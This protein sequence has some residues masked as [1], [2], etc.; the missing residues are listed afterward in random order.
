[1]TCGE[2]TGADI[3][4][5]IVNVN[6][7]VSATDA[8]VAAAQ[9]T[10]GRGTT[11]LGLTPR[12]GAD[13][14]DC[15]FESLLAAVAVMDAVVT[16]AP[17]DEEGVLAADA[18]ILG[19]FGEYGRDGLAE[20]LDVPVFDVAESGAH[21][22]MLL[23]RTFSVVTTL[24]RARAHIEDRLL[25]AGLDRKCASVR[26]TG[27]GTRALDDDPDASIDKIVSAAQ[28][29]IDE[30]GAEVIV[31]GCGGMAGWTERIAA[32][33]GV[34][35]IESIVAAV[36][37]AEAVVGLKLTTSKIGS[38]APPPAKALTGWPLSRLV[39]R[40]EAPPAG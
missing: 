13:G 30:D 1:M 2:G 19:G 38:Y 18:V 21:L 36:A 17:R 28:R 6:T 25:V 34:P 24:P 26:A 31:L 16:D 40:V 29:A 35:V 32:R 9:A 37:L 8:M 12:F 11:I 4:I 22:A 15:N 7:T 27:L 10:A 39:P 33:L 3:R 14:V 20:L 23:G 5:L